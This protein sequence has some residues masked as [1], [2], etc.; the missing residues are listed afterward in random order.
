MTISAPKSSGFC[1]YGVAKVLSTA[2]KILCSLVILATSSI[3]ANFINGFV[4]VSTQI[5]FVFSL[6]NDFNF[7]ISVISTK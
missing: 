4:G 3:S 1:K 5:N 6:I 2:N 7:A